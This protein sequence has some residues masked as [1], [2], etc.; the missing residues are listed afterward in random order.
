MIS[1]DKHP[2]VKASDELED[3]LRARAIRQVLG[4]GLAGLGAGA[5][6]RS[7]LELKRLLFG[8]PRRVEDTTTKRTEVPISIPGRAEASLHKAASNIRKV[9]QTRYGVNWWQVPASVAATGGGVVGGWK[10]LDKLLDDMRKADLKR[11]LKDARD[12]YERALREQ[13]ETALSKRGALDEVFE[14]LSV[15]WGDIWEYLKGA[16]VTAVL[17]TSGAAALGG[18]HL[19]K[20]RSRKQQLAELEKRRKELQLAAPEPPYV[21]AAVVH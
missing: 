14:K 8:H 9:A 5:G 17:G 21:Y 13:F 19:A 7:L 1:T 3:R 16:Y 15:D 12:D 11:E 20:S 18:Y 4:L 10:A 6:A 2:R